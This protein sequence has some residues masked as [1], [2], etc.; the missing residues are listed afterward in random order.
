MT[1]IYCKCRLHGSTK[2]LIAND[3]YDCTVDCTA[4]C[5]S[6]QGTFAYNSNAPE[7]IPDEPVAKPPKKG[8]FSRQED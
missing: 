3:G 7:D 2:T 1:T 6:T 4:A 5:V 8:Q